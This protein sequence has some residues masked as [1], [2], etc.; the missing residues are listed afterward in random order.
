[1]YEYQTLADD[2]LT[3]KPKTL[4]PKTLNHK[5]YTLS[6]ALWGSFPPPHRANQLILERVLCGGSIGAFAGDGVGR[7]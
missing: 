6:L 4:N 2:M 1:V 7:D 3:L 5:P